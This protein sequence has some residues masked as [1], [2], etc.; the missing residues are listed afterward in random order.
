M[1]D[2]R[3]QQEKREALANKGNLQRIADSLERIA[4]SLEIQYGRYIDD[5]GAPVRPGSGNPQDKKQ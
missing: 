4:D 5:D 2:E 1:K 3:S